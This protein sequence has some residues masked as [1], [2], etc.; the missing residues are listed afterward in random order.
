[1]VVCCLIPFQ[2]EADKDGSVVVG[3]FRHRE[4]LC[5]TVLAYLGFR[6]LSRGPWLV[7]DGRGRWRLLASYSE[8][9][10]V[11]SDPA[12]LIYCQHLY[13]KRFSFGRAI[14]SGLRPDVS[15]NP[16][17][18]GDSQEILGANRGSRKFQRHQRRARKK[19]RRSREF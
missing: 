7:L 18:L 19:A 5:G 10:W 1:M 13:L 17:A 9:D 4:R 3:A 6:W 14:F 16:K 11:H 8:P 2:K 12:M 15:R